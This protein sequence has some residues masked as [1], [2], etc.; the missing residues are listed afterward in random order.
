MMV[1]AVVAT[2]T[3]IFCVVLLGVSELGVTVQ[4]APVGAPVQVKVT[5]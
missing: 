1:G 5:V 3:V 2:L 4:V